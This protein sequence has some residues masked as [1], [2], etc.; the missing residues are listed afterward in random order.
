M[1]DSGS[2]NALINEVLVGNKK[3]FVQLI[4]QYEGLVL[5]IVTPL[6]GINQ[7]REDICQDVFIKVY[8]KLNT[9]QFKSKLA[10]W[11]GNIAYNTSIN[12]LQKKRNVLLS[13]LLSV[14]E[15]KSFID[16]LESDYNNPEQIIIK[17]E[18]INE[19]NKNITKLPEIQKS[20]LLLFYK[21]ELSVDEISRIM[22]MPINTIKSHLF[23]A[24]KSLKQLSI[25]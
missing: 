1:V 11:I 22:E 13:D 4:H 20:I 14:N 23:R 25:N 3:A 21:D 2:E 7:D 5:H 16:E 17:K 8:E 18:N 15:D 19:L 12:F 24:R 6:I 9:F 10:T